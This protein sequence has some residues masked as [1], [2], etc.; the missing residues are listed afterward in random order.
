MLQSRREFFEGL[1]ILKFPVTVQRLSFRRGDEI[2]PT[3]FAQRHV[4][5]AGNEMHQQKVVFW[6]NRNTLMSASSTRPSWGIS[7]EEMVIRSMTAAYGP[8]SS[9][10]NMII[11]SSAVVSAKETSPCMAARSLF[12][13]PSGVTETCSP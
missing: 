7:A 1:A 8:K 4:R 12:N 13:V 10:E 6:M 3:A 11:S 2:P 5:F 9:S